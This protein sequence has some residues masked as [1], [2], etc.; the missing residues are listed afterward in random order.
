MPC[1]NESLVI[2]SMHTP[3]ACKPARWGQILSMPPHV[4]SGGLSP[5]FTPQSKGLKLRLIYC[6]W[7]ALACGSSNPCEAGNPAE[8]E[9]RAAGFA[10]TWH[11]FQA[12]RERHRFSGLASYYNGVRFYLV[13][14][15]ILQPL[16][17]G[18]S[19]ILDNGI[20]LGRGSAF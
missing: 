9:R 19:F 5:E 3:A 7:L 4:V 20:F 10:D 6:L 11:E 16:K 8:P 1:I 13:G 15:D 17:P 12:D 14:E 2:R 18:E